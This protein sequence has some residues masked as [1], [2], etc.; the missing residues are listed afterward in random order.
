[1][2]GTGQVGTIVNRAPSQTKIKATIFGK[3]AHAGI[4]PEKGISAINLAAKAI[5]KMNLGR[6][7]DESNIK[8]R[9]N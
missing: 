3:K 9:Y 7:D 6:I 8:Y 5:S 1:M 2:D 4:E